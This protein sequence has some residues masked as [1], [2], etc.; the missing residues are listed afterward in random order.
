MKTFFHSAALFAAGFL[1]CSL[2]QLQHAAQDEVRARQFVLVDAKGAEIGRFG[3]KSK[4]AKLTLRTE[5]NGQTTIE[6]GEGSASLLL[7]G[8]DS[9]ISA[10]AYLGTTSFSLASEL[11]GSHRGLDGCLFTTGNGESSLSVNSAKH[12]TRIAARA[13]GAGALLIVKDPKGQKTVSCTPTGYYEM[14]ESKGGQ[15]A[16]E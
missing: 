16:G 3:S 9:R 13:L 11:E 7:E 4:S 6:S 14:Q 8:R 1:C 5:G 15:A 10:N 2:G 12:D